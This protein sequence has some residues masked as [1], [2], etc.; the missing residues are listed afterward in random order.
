MLK[1]LL[2]RR[3]AGSDDDV[4]SQLELLSERNRKRRDPDLERRLLRLRQQAFAELEPAPGQ[5]AEPDSRSFEVEQGVPVL[6]PEELSAAAVRAAILEYGCLHVPRLFDTERV[7]QLKDGIDRAF[8]ACA[9]R[10]GEE[11][12]ADGDREWYE[13][14]KP[15]PGYT[16]G[17]GREWN[18]SSGAIWAADSPP[19]MFELLEAF[20][21]LGVRATVTEYLGER[22][23]LSMNKTVLR[24]ATPSASGAD[25]HQDGAFLGGEIRSINLWLSLS[26]CGI[27]SPGMDMVPKRLDEIVQ[28]GGEGASFDWSVAPADAERVAGETGIVRPV[29]EPGDALLFDHLFLHRTG[30][31]PTM[32]ETRYAIESWFFA[33]SAYPAKQAP[34]VV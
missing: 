10:E 24:K 29:F 32:T 17:G 15:L 7:E 28:T 8:A 25:W 27:D 2:S 14:F 30:A 12:N 5:A 19:V 21:E 3:R 9:A 1:S 33:P 4:F 20:E 26:R 31:E 18:L 23:A 34:L 6:A 13:P 11:G 16:L 22:P